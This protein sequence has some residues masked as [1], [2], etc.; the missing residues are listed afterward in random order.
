MDEIKPSRG[1]GG[2]DRHPPDA[3][4]EEPEPRR[5]F[6][7]MRGQFKVGPEFFEPLPP[8]E[9]DLWYQ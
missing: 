5:R 9:L 6:G 4:S 1:G 8:E 2:S 7:A 3:A